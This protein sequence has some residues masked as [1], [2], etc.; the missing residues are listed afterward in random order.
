MP[1]KI[2]R[3]VNSRGCKSDNGR[4]ATTRHLTRILIYLKEIVDYTYHN[5]L[6]DNLPIP[7]NKVKDALLFLTNH[8]L[9]KTMDWKYCSKKVYYL[10]EKESIVKAHYKLDQLKHNFKYNNNK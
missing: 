1:P 7:P 4:S 10:P 3:S 9:I 5:D 2:K 6:R 8:D